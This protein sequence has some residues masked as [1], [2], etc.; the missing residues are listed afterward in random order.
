VE[1]HKVLSKHVKKLLPEKYLAD[2]AMQAFLESVSN[3]YYVFERVNK[4]SEHAFEVSEREYQEINNSFKL[5]KEVAEN[6]TLA[7]SQFLSTMSHEIRTPMNAV[8]GFTHLLQQLDPR[9]EQAEYLNLLKFSAEN[10]LGLI[11]DVLDFSKIEAGKIEFEE[12]DFNIK[13]LINNIRLSLLKNATEKNIGVEILFDSKLPIMV[14]GDSIRLGQILINLINNAIKFTNVGK[15]TISALLNKKSKDYTVFDFEVSDTGIGI[16]AAKIESIFESFTQAA[17]D[18]SRKFGGTGLGLAIT[19]KL[20]ELMGSEIKVRSELGIKSVFY[21]TLSMKNSSEVLIDNTDNQ[22]SI[23]QK[24]FNGIKIL[25]ADDNHIN[26]IMI[27]QFM[28]LWGAECDTAENGSIA[29]EMVKTNNYQMVLMDLEMPVMDGY[30]CAAAIRHLP[31]DFF[32]NLPIIALTASSIHTIKDKAHMV[33]MNDFISKPFNPDEL[34]S[35]IALYSN[36]ITC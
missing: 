11:N 31:G 16:E 3:S 8:I 10:L 25:I 32:K 2:E 26:I 21:F 1:Y 15:V 9:P 34:Y 27:K 28:K 14:K 36:P 22:F 4:I 18:T 5:S 12:A 23:K 29:L 20:L 17:A 24:S 30:Q 35:K 13:D 19:R 6:A 33:G 7:K